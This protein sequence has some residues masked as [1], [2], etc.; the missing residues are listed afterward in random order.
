MCSSDLF[1][2]ARSQ[3][4]Q[5]SARC[6]QRAFLGD[7]YVRS[8]VAARRLVG[9]AAALNLSVD[10]LSCTRDLEA[11]AEVVLDCMAAGLSRVALLQ[12]YGDCEINWDTHRNDPVQDTN[13]DA[14]FSR[15][16]TIL[17]MIAARTSASGAP[18]ADELTVVVVSEMNRTP[19]L[20]YDGGREHWPYTSAMLIGSGVRGGQVIGQMDDG[21]IGQKIDLATGELDDGGDAITGAHLGATLLAL[22]SVEA[23]DRFVGDVQPIEAALS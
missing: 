11:D 17:N 16:D 3:A 6:G 2:E 7:H 22:G 21:F 12:D 8:L 10:A 14:F 13:F 1:V 18:L 23:P 9:E 5:E 19:Y 20:N 4:W 15:L